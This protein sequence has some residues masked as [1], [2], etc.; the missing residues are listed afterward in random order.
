M[1]PEFG[2]VTWRRW[3]NPFPAWTLVGLLAL[4]LLVF[5]VVGFFLYEPM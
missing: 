2:R 1:H 5:S 4:V 3:F